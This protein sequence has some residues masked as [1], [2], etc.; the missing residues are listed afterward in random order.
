MKICKD[1]K[2]KEKLW[3]GPAHLMKCWHP[4]STRFDIVTGKPDYTFCSISRKYGPCDI[5]GK[6]WEAK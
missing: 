5:E 4:H 3:L 1:C 6:L 2:Y